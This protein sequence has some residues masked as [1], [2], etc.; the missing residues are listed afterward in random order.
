MTLSS[1][2]PW[3]TVAVIQGYALG[4]GLELALVCDFRIASAE[5]TFGSPELQHGWLPG[6]GGINRLK[7]LLGASRAKEIIFLGDHIPAEEAFRIGLINRISKPELLEQE[8]E[9]VLEK[10]L[11]LDP[12]VFAMAKAA[13]SKPAGTEGASR[14]DA[15]FDIL[16]TI[17]VKSGIE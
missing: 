5:A 16:S 10:L 11:K 15:W 12:E 2:Y 6:W 4:G 8:T 13:I 14:H 7:Q 1:A 17:F 9:N 3:L